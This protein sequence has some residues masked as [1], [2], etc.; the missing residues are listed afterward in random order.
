M[1]AINERLAELERA[2]AQ[3]ETALKDAPEGKLH[4]IDRGKYLEFY[5]RNKGEKTGR[6]IRK[7][8]IKQ[9]K[10]LVQN[11][12]YEKAL[13][14]IVTEGEILKEFN[15]KYCDLPDD[16]RAIYSN[17]KTKIKEYIEPF[18]MN[19]EDYIEKWQSEKYIEKEISDHIPVYITDR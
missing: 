10:K 9:I 12:Y 6:Y 11:S 19:D 18:D 8:D 4:I 16:L 2:R 17:D 3:A 14:N 15:K 7:S 5:I 13:G 1:S